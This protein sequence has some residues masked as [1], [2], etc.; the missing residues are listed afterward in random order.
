MTI[1]WSMHNFEWLLWLEIT[2]YRN[3]TNFSWKVGEPRDTCIFQI[4]FWI[5]SYFIVKW[6]VLTSDPLFQT[7]PIYYIVNDFFKIKLLVSCSSAFCKPYTLF[8]TGIANGL[9][10]EWLNRRGVAKC[11]TLW[12][13]ALSQWSRLT[14]LLYLAFYHTMTKIQIYLKSKSSNVSRFFSRPIEFSEKPS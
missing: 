8:C 9:I 2:Y 12:M 14:T 11:S 10:M 13:H 3:L 5:Y 4:F 6:R 1:L 7:C